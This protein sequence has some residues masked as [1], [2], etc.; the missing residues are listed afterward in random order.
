MIRSNPS[1]YISVVLTAYNRQIFL[2]HAIESLA[3]QNLDFSKFEVILLTNFDINILLLETFKKRGGNIKILKLDGPIGYYFE[4]ALEISSGEILCFLDDDDS[5]SYNKLKVV[6]DTFIHNDKIGYYSNYINIIDEYG[7]T[8]KSRSKIGDIFKTRKGSEIIINNNSNYRLIQKFIDY[9]GNA[10]NSTISIRK[11]ILQ[12]Y[13]S[14]LKYI[15]RT[16]DEIIFS[17][18]LD[19]GYNLMLNSLKLTNYRI[20]GTNSS[21]ISL[22]SKKTINSRCNVI[23][24]E[25]CTF[26]NIL[27]TDNLLK[28]QVTRHYLGNSYSFDYLLSLSICSRCNIKYNNTKINLIK[29]LLDPVKT[30][31]IFLILLYFLSRIHRKLAIKFYFVFRG[32]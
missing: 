8:Y 24:K 19:S 9:G 32:D 18:A 2:K 21:R 15:L 12:N 1:P 11:S 25:L 13:K 20:S 7:R 30:S 4:R 28:N 23:K 17:I 5:F 22:K 16:E 26:Y 29:N 3:N 10:L 27:N 31:N 6:M 14:G